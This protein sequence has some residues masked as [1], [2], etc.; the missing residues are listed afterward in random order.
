ML[1]SPVLVERH[2]YL[3]YSS[4]V[5]ADDEEC[6]HDPAWLWVQASNLRRSGD[7]VVRF[8]LAHGFCLIY[9]CIE[10]QAVVFC[11]RLWILVDLINWIDSLRVAHILQVSVVNALNCLTASLYLY[12]R[13]S[14][15]NE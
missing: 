12:L 8:N 3:N 5:C 14:V 6:V 13:S 10:I 1:D 4:V 15:M 2:V 7:R 11:V 9:G